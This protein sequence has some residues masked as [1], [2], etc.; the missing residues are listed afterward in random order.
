ME[1]P[2]ISYYYA[3]VFHSIVV[4]EHTVYVLNSLE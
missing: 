2:Q 1:T 3:L 4:E